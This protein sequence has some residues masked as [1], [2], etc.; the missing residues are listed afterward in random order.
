MYPDQK[1]GGKKIYKFIFISF[2]M[3]EIT[4]TGVISL[5]P[6]TECF[7]ENPRGVIMMFM[8]GKVKC[9]L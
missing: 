2:L 3:K 7:C 1:K 4:K 5:K 6:S 8:I 9:E